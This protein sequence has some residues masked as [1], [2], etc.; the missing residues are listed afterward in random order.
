MIVPTPHELQNAAEPVIRPDLAASPQM[1]S[2]PMTKKQ[3]RKAARRR[4]RN[5]LG[6]RG[7][8]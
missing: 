6:F 7:P 1:Q 2:L 3:A 4:K 8:R 5:P